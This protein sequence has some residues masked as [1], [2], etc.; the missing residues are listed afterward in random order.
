MEYNRAFS[1]YCWMRATMLLVLLPITACAHYDYA[2]GPG[3]SAMNLGPDMARCRI[4]ARGA[5]PGFGFGVSGP[6]RFVAAAAAGAVVGHAIGSAIRQNENY[7]DCMQ[8]RGWRVVQPRVAAAQPLVAPAPGQALLT[9]VAMRTPKL[10]AE[11]PPVALV[12]TSP[13]PS[14]IVSPAPPTTVGTVA[15]PLPRRALGLNVMGMT[16]P[17]A[18]A[19]S[20]PSA[21][22]LFVVDVVGGGAA[23]DAGLRCND[24]VLALGPNPLNSVGDLQAA[25]AGVAHGSVVPATIWR[26]G[27]PQVVSLLF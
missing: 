12:P 26:G 11:P 22:G 9:P 5:E 1:H 16:A 27:R 4:F 19:S 24:V 7:N 6:P 8:A 13:A 14:P 21:E 23:A 20:L 15:A 10:T 2:P 3:M 25:L 17:L 18:V